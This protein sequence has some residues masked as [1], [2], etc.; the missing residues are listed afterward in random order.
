M[1]SL[2]LLQ[3]WCGDD[4][5]AEVLSNCWLRAASWQT[6]HGENTLSHNSLFSILCTLEVSTDIR[7][8]SQCSHSG[9]LL[10]E[11]TRYNSLALS[12]LGLVL[13][14]SD[15][16]ESE[17]SRSPV[18]SSSKSIQPSLQLVHLWIMFVQVLPPVISHS[19]VGSDML[20]VIW[21]AGTGVV[22]LV[23]NGTS[24]E[25]FSGTAH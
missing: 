16:F 9:I 14:F 22:A 25:S 17:I 11:S 12:Q 18:D 2:L 8:I 6:L 4:W 23:R 15:H 5:A 3:L 13:V 7:E 24:T 19:N 20:I 10:V 21:A 1:Q